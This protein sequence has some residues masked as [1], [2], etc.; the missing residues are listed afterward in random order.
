MLPARRRGAAG[1][2]GTGAHCD[3]RPAGP[4]RAGAGPCRRAAEYR[5]FG[6][7]GRPAGPCRPHRTDPAA[8][9]GA[10]RPKHAALRRGGPG[11][12]RPVRAGS[13]GRFG[14][15]AA[16]PGTAVPERDRHGGRIFRGEVPAPP[17]PER[18]RHPVPDVR[19]HRGTGHGAAVQK[20]ERAGVQS[21][22]AGHDLGHFPPAENA[23]GRWRSRSAS[24]MPG[25]A[26][27]AIF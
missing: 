13:H 25:P 23:A 15:V 14:P 24:I 16:P 7:G 3:R 17:A 22:F 20:R 21:L 1:P 2:A 9:A 8:A 6:Q 27:A 12:R 18:E 10:A 19:R 26:S 4:G 5:A 11:R